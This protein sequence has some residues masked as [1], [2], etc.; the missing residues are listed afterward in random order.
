[1]IDLS[2]FEIVN[3]DTKIYFYICKINSSGLIAF[4]LPNLVEKASLM[5]MDGDESAILIFRQ[6]EN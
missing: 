5:I 4:T 2:S 1:M 6:S 3:K